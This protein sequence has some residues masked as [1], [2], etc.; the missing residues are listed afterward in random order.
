[1]IA[2]A[3]GPGSGGVYGR[4]MLPIASRA[5]VVAAILTLVGA[6]CSSSAQEPVQLGTERAVAAEQLDQA[7]EDLVLLDGGPPG[8]AVVVQRDT[9]STLH[10]A[11]TGT[12]EKDDTIRRNDH[13]RI[14]SVTKAYTGAASL[15]AVAA[16]DL[17]LD[18]TIG[19]LLPAQPVAWHGVTLAQLLQHTSGLPD[20]SR[21]ESFQAAVHDS[22]DVAPPP[23]SLLAFVADQ[24]LAFPPGSRYQYSNSDSIAAALMVQAATG[25]PWATVLREEVFDPARL[26][27]TS[28]PLGVEMPDPVVHGYTRDS[29]DPPEDVTEVLA[30]GWSWASGG[31]VSTPADSNRFVRS[32]ARGAL[33]D[34]PTL[35]AQR[36][37][38]PGSSEPPGPGLNRAGLGI[39]RYDTRCG[40]VF[41]HTGNTLG[42]T[43]FV[44]ATADG[45]QSLSV[46]VNAQITPR[47]APKI[48]PALRRV[49]T[50]AVCTAL[51]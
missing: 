36:V 42:Y 18:T 15:A 25:E 51:V 17:S 5:S 38:R 31:I 3:D 44:A 1:M 9:T 16:G 39:F 32:Y 37:V 19:E 30:G 29:E 43:H 40:T 46:S 27:E 2:P 50:L 34:P 33:T 48:F 24:A 10:R 26:T 13:V 12:V 23:D 20:F 41:G 6:A 22:P 49:F 45:R 14:A 11:G 4:S 8:V 47:T 28:L 35:R 21:S 7:L